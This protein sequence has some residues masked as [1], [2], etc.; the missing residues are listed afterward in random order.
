MKTCTKCGETKAL[1]C[2]YDHRRDRKMARCK[3]CQRAYQ[4]AHKKAHPEKAR[5]AGSAHRSHVVIE[6]AIRDAAIEAR[7]LEQADARDYAYFFRIMTRA[8]YQ[9]EVAED[10]ARQAAEY[11]RARRATR[12]DS[13]RTKE[14]EYRM[15]N[16]EKRKAYAKKRY[17][18]NPD[19]FKENRLKNKDYIVNYCRTKRATL[20]DSYVADLTA[21]M[22]PA[23]LSIENIPVHLLDARRLIIETKRTL[24]NIKN[25]T[26]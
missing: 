4:S 12:G 14:R 10:R 19:M 17:E 5:E 2:F 22:L 9:S 11:R 25:E 24:R 16:T 18:E 8:I 20:A 7:K 6:K 13:I 3:V 1:D 15:K 26:H 23:G 21:Q